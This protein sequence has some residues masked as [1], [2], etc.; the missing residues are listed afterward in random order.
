MWSHKLW[1]TA[2]RQSTIMIQ[3][4]C[5]LHTVEGRGWNR[6]LLNSVEE[7]MWTCGLVEMWTCGHVDMW[8]CG[9][10][11]L[12]T[13]GHVEGERKR[14]GGARRPR[15]IKSQLWK[16]PP[17]LP[18]GRAPLILPI[19]ISHFQLEEL[20]LRLLL[21]LTQSI[22]FGSHTRK[23]TSPWMN[24]LFSIWCTQQSAIKVWVVQIVNWIELNIEKRKTIYLCVPSWNTQNITYF[25]K[26]ENCTFWTQNFRVIQ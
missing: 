20:T 9:H 3:S 1:S 17:H 23:L 24:S 18:A 15:E 16:S 19:S 21:T 14:C 22:T 2:Q 13:C 4:V 10:V 12:W 25:V 26:A 11:D 8:T 5:G 7:D 6:K